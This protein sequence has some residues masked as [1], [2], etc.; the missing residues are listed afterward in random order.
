MLLVFLSR[1]HSR[2]WISLKCLSTKAYIP[3]HGM[4]AALIFLSG[5]LLMT[6]S[7]SQHSHRNVL[8]NLAMVAQIIILYILLREALVIV[9]NT[10]DAKKCRLFPLLV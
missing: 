7:M 1:I 3:A 2:S 9:Q 10:A 4:L 5:L 6:I 8:V